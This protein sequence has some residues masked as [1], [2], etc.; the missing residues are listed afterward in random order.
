M[1]LIQK[2][3]KKTKIINYFINPI[4][5]K[6][7]LNL[8]FIFSK[9]K[10]AKFICVSNV[11]S[12]IESFLNKDFKK[13]H[14]SADIAI[15]D[16]RP[17]FWALKMLGKKKA[18]HLPGYLITDKICDFAN[19]YNLKIGF[20]G[21]SFIVLNQLDKNLKKKYNNLKI[22]YK[23][24]PP[25]TK[26]NEINKK[27]I[28]SKINK[29]KVDILFVCLGCPKQELWMHEHKSKLKCTMI[30]IGAVADFLSGNKILPNKFFEYLGLAWMI[31]LFSEP[32]RLFWRYFSTNFLFIFLF[33]LQ[34]TGLKSFK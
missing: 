23:Y 13:A 6:D 5:L 14:N 24:S 34:I 15:P 32:R 17:I 20:Y 4:N 27:K 12:C 30:G 25:F 33:I 9:K 11:H 3:Y 22:N 18:E 31:R 26:I 21:S 1:S 19:K 29:S 10:K 7:F 16:G 8:I 2:N 28:L